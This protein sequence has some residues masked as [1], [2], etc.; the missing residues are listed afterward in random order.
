MSTSPNEAGP[1]HDHALADMFVEGEQ[2]DIRHVAGRKRASWFVK[3]GSIW[4]K[5]EHSLVEYKV[6]EFLNGL[7]VD[8]EMRLGADRTI[9]AVVNQ[10]RN[11]PRVTTSYD[12][13]DR[14][15]HL[16]GTPGGI[17]N[18]R[19]GNLHRS[20]NDPLITKSTSV[21]P[22][23]EASCAA[24]DNFI[25][26]F[27][28]GDTQLIRYLQTWCGYCLTGETS[29]HAM[30]ILYGSG[31]NGKSTF[32]EVLRDILTDYAK[33]PDRN[34]FVSGGRNAHFAATSHLIGARLVAAPEI[35]KG[36]IWNESI[37]KA[38]TGGD[39]IDA[40]GMWAEQTDYRPSGKLI[41]YTNHLPDPKAVN[42]ALVRRLQIFETEFSI[43]EPDTSLKPR[44]EKEFPAILAW[45]IEGAKRYYR[46]Y[47]KGK[48]GIKVPEYVTETTLEYLA[49]FDF[50]QQWWDLYVIEREGEITHA[51]DMEASLNTYLRRIN[52]RPIGK[53]EVGKLMSG[54][55]YK[56]KSERVGPKQIRRHHGVRLRTNP[57]SS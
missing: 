42:K 17:I 9:R 7:N 45:M 19:T 35:E 54:K 33:V 57:R 14:D 6:R 21:A 12:A 48:K 18:L 56:S 26:Q 46:R 31:S 47:D 51:T 52:E 1:L 24:W 30:L 50:F 23:F 29:D 28:M 36:A 22:D 53:I 25:H 10:A 37:L 55:G 43:D 40:K 32:V 2:I 5:D 3:V 44:L 4:Q 38:F 15:S 20:R 16:L 8:G 34:L 11:D 39:T 49:Q 27:A 13:L 41:V